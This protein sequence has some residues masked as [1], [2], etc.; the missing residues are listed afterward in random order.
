[1]TNANKLRDRVTQYRKT[2]TPD[3]AGGW[4]IAWQAV[5]DLWCEVKT[6]TG[7]AVFI[8]DGRREKESCLLTFR[9]GVDVVMGDRMKWR[10]TYIDI[11]NVTP[12]EGVPLWI[13]ARGD[14]VQAGEA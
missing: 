3:G 6:L 10:G 12:V 11:A 2:R 5:T 4:V 13:E 8:H 7:K 9:A 14:I 1:M